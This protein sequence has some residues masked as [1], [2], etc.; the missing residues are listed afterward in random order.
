MNVFVVPH[1][2]VVLN[3]SC[4]LSCGLPCLAAQQLSC[5]TK[6]E[7]M[8]AT[9]NLVSMTAESDCQVFTGI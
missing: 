4:D 3:V 8:V 5:K 1:L 9:V 6:V 2:F 7:E